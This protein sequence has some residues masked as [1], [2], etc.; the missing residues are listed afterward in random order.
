M[1][2]KAETMSLC[3]LS[4]KVSKIT[5][6]GSQGSNK[7][8]SPCVF[9]CSM[10]AQARG[11]SV[12]GPCPMKLIIPSLIEY[13]FIIG[14][15]KRPSLKR[16]MEQVSRVR[17]IH[18]NS[19][20]L[21]VKGE[22]RPQV[23]GPWYVVDKCETFLEWI[24]WNFIIEMRKSKMWFLFQHARL[25]RTLMVISNHLFD[26]PESHTFLIRPMKMVDLSQKTTQTQHKTKS[27]NKKTKNKNNKPTKQ[28]N[29]QQ[30]YQ[31]TPVLSAC[32]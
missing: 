11:P 26:L 19:Q 18:V 9:V 13:K 2:L 23:L 14:R 31:K 15:L 12:I 7:T 20:R 21:P 17:S 3:L 30:H 16:L 32:S 28:R 1:R 22:L 29:T 4:P 10:C 24:C 25:L 6:R 5:K 27:T 8:N